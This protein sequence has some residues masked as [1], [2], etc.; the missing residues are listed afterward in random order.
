MTAP[1][2]PEAQAPAET[3]PEQSPA[4]THSTYTDGVYTGTGT[5]YRGAT[6]V[7]VTVESGRITDVT[8]LSYADDRQYFARAQSSL[9]AAI[10]NQQGVD[11]S[12]VS[13][14]TFSSNGILEAVADALNI[15]FTNPNASLGGRRK[16]RS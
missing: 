10:L 3:A 15:D 1:T 14:A 7:Q 8:V 6:Q 12:T 13:G 4:L 2:Q 5:G 16:G 9:I 11:V